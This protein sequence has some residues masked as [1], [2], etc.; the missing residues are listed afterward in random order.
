MLVLISD[1]SLRQQIMRIAGPAIVE[2]IMYM[3]IGVVDIAIVGRLGAIPLAA[4]SLGSEIF[5]SIVLFMEALAIGSAVLVAQ[6]VGARNLSEARR[7][8]VHTL[9]LATILGIIAM[10]A[11]LVYTDK[12]LGLFAVETDVFRQARDYLIITFRITPLALILYMTNSIFRGLGRTDIPMVIALIVN[13]FN[14]VGDYVLV[15]GLA[16]FPALGVAG[17]AWATALAHSLGF[18]LAIYM[19]MSGKGGL[20][21]RWGHVGRIDPAVFRRILNLGIPSLAEQF[22]FNASNL[23]SIYLLVYLGTMAYASHQVALTVESIS[24]M[25]GFGIAVAATTLVGQNVGAGNQSSLVKA[26]RG[27][28]EFGL[29]VMGI[30]ALLFALIPFQIAAIFTN[31]QHIINLAGSII[32]LA[33]LE[34]LTIATSMVIEGILKGTGDTRTPMLISTLAT[35]GYRLPLLYVFIK[36]WHLDIIYVWIL[37]IMDWLFRTLVYITIY[38]RKKWLKNIRTPYQSNH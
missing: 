26:A 10:I 8:T 33:S 31:D 23:I 35:W 19:L 13:I 36:V 6:A 29:L 25:P 5:F 30:F 2:M 34:Q 20:T 4:V 14:I 11:G 12:I 21:I 16:G 15:Y 3:V 7:V 28:I 38:R 9:L 22:F 32:R 24:F 37:Y 1:K 18:A 27:S 17:A